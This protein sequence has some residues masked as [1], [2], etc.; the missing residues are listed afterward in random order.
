MTKLS[1]ELLVLTSLDLALLRPEAPGS[2]EQEESG[3]PFPHLLHIEDL[4][5]ECETCHSDEPDSDPVCA[6]YHGNQQEG[7]ANWKV[8][9]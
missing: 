8:K 1:I 9:S 2:V 7:P 3:T 6:T 5:L 4:E